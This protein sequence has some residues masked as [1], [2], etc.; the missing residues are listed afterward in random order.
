MSEG[1]HFKKEELT[2]ETK[3]PKIEMPTCEYV[4]DYERAFLALLVYFWPGRDIKMSNEAPFIP[5]PVQTLME[6]VSS[7]SV[8]SDLRRLATSSVNP[9]KFYCTLKNS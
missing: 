3:R 2:L 1:N 6:C 5:V 9:S 8:C 7:S 4:S